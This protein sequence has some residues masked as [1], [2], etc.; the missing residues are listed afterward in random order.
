MAVNSALSGKH[1]WNCSL[2]IGFEVE[3]WGAY[4]RLSDGGRENR[5]MAQE[6]VLVNVYD[7]VSSDALLIMHATA[8]H[9]T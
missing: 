1:C 7:M 6:P 3:S 4:V 2:T 9:W 5:T 8:E